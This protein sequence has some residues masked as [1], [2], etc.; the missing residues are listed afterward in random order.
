MFIQACEELRHAENERLAFTGIYAAIVG[1]VLSF[2]SQV[3]PAVSVATRLYVT[4]FLIA[5]TIIGL[6]IS[7]RARLPSMT[8]SMR[9]TAC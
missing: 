5:L 8:G 4:G 6:V 2:L 9:C 3:T 1:G 7:L